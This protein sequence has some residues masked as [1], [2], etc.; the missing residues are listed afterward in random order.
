VLETNC[1]S[2]ADLLFVTSHQNRVSNARWQAFVHVPI[3]CANT[4]LSV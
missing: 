2:H 1:L 3:V 4:I